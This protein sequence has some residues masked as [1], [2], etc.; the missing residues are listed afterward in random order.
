MT[1]RQRWIDAKKYEKSKH[2]LLQLFRSLELCVA[3]AHTPCAIVRPAIFFLLL[4]LLFLHSHCVLCPSYMWLFGRANKCL[5]CIFIYF[6]LIQAS[7]QLFRFR[8]NH[9]WLRDAECQENRAMAV[10]RSFGRPD[11]WHTVM[12]F[13]VCA[14]ENKIDHGCRFGREIFMIFFLFSL[15]LAFHVAN[16]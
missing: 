8:Q 16:L 15:L 2:V 10:A 1:S 7:V 12:D 13:N 14:G 9:D 6:Y 4:L 11:H 5:K 3:R